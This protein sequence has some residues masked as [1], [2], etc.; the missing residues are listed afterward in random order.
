MVTTETATDYVV[1][2]QAIMLHCRR[3]RSQRQE[4]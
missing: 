2:N 3:Q 4:Q 1:K